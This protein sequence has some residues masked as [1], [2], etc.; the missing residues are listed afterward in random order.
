VSHAELELEWQKYLSLREQANEDWQ[1][2]ARITALVAEQFMAD[3]PHGGDL[4]SLKVTFVSATQK[5][6]EVVAQYRA[7]LTPATRRLT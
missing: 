6:R 5:T 3:S 7:W 1:R 4:D 2:L